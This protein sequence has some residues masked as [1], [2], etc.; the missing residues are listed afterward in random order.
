MRVIRD[1]YLSDS[2]VTIFLIGTR[3]SENLG[4][5]EQA[6]IK[7]E[8][9][10]SLYDGK[11]NSR[12]GLLGVVLPSMIQTI[13]PGAYNC[14]VC[15]GSHNLVKLDDTTVVKEFWYNYYIPNNRCAHFEDDRYCVLVTWENFT[16]DPNLYIDEAFDKRSSDISSRVKVYP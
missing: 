12:S 3:S 5:L 8:L 7:R 6:Y 9:Q 13:F 16:R 15:G 10:A 4:A 1:R 2:T 11:A 14:P